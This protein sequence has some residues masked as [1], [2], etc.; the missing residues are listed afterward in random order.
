MLNN[1]P[2][3]WGAATHREKLFLYAVGRPI[4]AAHSNLPHKK[5]G[6]KFV[7]AYRGF[8]RRA[9]LSSPG[10]RNTIVFN[11]FFFNFCILYLLFAS[12]ASMFLQNST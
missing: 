4:L 1:R 11:I 5:F 9:R 2:R 10:R 6:G 8:A 7:A 12:I 3:L